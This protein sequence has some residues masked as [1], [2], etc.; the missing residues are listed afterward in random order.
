MVKVGV[1]GT[2]AEVGGVW[3]SNGI[4]WSPRG[5]TMY[6]ADSPRRRVEAYDFDAESG[7]LRNGRVFARMPD[8]DGVPDGMCVDEGGGVWVCVWDAGKVLRYV[9][10]GEGNA[11]L[12]RTIAF[13][14]SRPT[15]CCF[16]GKDGTTLFVTSCSLDT[17]VDADAKDVS[18]DEPTAGGVFAI[19][20]GVKGVPVH[21]AAF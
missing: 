19:D 9:P 18:A 7:L 21:A 2:V 11:R 14:C 10:D 20:V 15:S 5:D 4:A 13:P 16:G 6:Y 3:T 12:D 8:D 17:T 1:A